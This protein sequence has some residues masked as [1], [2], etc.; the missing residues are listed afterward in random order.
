MRT[1]YIDSVNKTI[2]LIFDYD[3]ELIKA[4]KLCDYSARWNS[5]FKEWRISINSYSRGHIS[6]LVKTH[7]FAHKA[8]EIEGEVKVSYAIEGIDRAY[9]RGMIDSKDFFYKARDYQIDALGYAMD[10][11]S[12]INGDDVGLGKTFEAILYAEVTNSFPC[13]VVVPASVKDQWKKEW[14]KITNHKTTISVI[15]SKPTKKKPNNWD[16]QVVI[17]NYDILAKKRGTGATY[18]FDELKDIKWKMGVF[19]EAHFLKNAKSQRSKIASRIISDDMR[20]QLLT[21]TATMNKPIELW[22]LLC[23]IGKQTQIVNDWMQFVTRYCDGHKGKFGWVTSGA[24]NTMELNRRLRETC[25]VRR[26]KSDVLK[27]LPDIIKQSIDIP[28]T[29]LKEYREAEIDLIAFLER[30]QGSDKADKAREAEH[31]VALGLLRK[32][33]AKG[34]IKAVEQY[35]KDWKESGRKLV[36]FGIHTEGLEY[37]AEKFK[38]PLITGS[39]NSSKKQQIKE[40]W[41]AGDDIFLFGNIQS[42]GTGVDG[43]QKVCSDELIYELPW[44]PSDLTQVMGRVHRS[45]QKEVPCVTFLIAPETIDTEMWAML[46]EKEAITDAV[47]KGIDVRRGNSGMRE[48]IKKILKRK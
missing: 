21:G 13:L 25:Y 5:E 18:R 38:C 14:S 47:N 33:S 36:V 32:M 43:L 11:G 9:F 8:K 41:I 19:D 30:T 12:I 26:E 23:L 6:R 31:L 20:I 22:N 27:D 4:I 28:I 7:G 2:N 45:G 1:Y 48:V 24:T 16:A 46:E 44:R 37:L 35:L 29:N 39:V 42:L 15:E 10:K 34:K 40:D 3:E 17:L